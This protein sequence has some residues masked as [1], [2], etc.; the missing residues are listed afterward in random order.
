MEIQKRQVQKRESCH[1]IVCFSHLPTAPQPWATQEAGPGVRC[2][3]GQRQSGSVE[4]TPNLERQDLESGPSFTVSPA[5]SLIL[6]WPLQLEERVAVPL[7]SRTGILNRIFVCDSVSSSYLLLDLPRAFVAPLKR[8]NSQFSMGK[9]DP[10]FSQAV[11][12][13]TSLI[14]RSPISKQRY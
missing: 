13:L 3:V 4:S 14:L 2:L 9:A 10:D 6:S 8:A 7:F 11:P 1:R 12:H 5:R